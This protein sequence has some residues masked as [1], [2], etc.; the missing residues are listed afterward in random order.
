MADTRSIQA[1]L[2]AAMAAV[3]LAGASAQSSSCSSAIMSLSP[4]LDYITGNASTPSSSCCSQLSSV[5]Q[6]EP[7]CICTLISSG[8]SSASS[9]G[10][11]VNQT[12]AL[13]LPSAC[14]VQIPLSQCNVS[15]PS[16]SPA[17][18]S[19]S[20]SGVGS[21]SNPATSTDSS[22]GASAGVPLALL[23]SL[24]AIGAYPFTSLV[25]V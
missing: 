15:G 21:K 9:L 6:S 10:I 8:A 5:V 25:S 2:V 11:T 1:I 13:A 16:A 20:P 3:L 24:V 23:L 7:Q 18:P 17:R 19:T 4:C 12:Q 22:D 14:K